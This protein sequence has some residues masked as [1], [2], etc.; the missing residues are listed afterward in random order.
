LRESALPPGA[1][2]MFRQPTLWQQH[3]NLVIGG[4][5]AFGLQTA[6]VAVLLIQM[7][8]RRQAESSLEES[9]ERIAYTAASTNTGL[10]HLDVAGDRG[11]ATDHCRA[12][13]GLAHQAPF[14]LKAILGAVHPED[15]HWVEEAIERATRFGAPIEAEL[16]I[17]V[18][19]REERWFVMRARPH[20]DAHG[21][22]ARI[23]G[24]FADV[25]ARKTAEAE[26]QARRAELAHLTRVSLLGE[27]SGAIAHELNQPLTAILANAQAARLVLAQKKPDLDLIREVIDDIEAEDNRAGEVIHRLRRL[28]RKGESQ[29]EAVNLNDLV[30]STLRVLHSELI[31]RKIKI[32]V[33][34]AGDLPTAAGDPVQL[35][36][37][38]L[39][40][41]MNAME[42]MDATAPA[43]RLITVRTRSDGNGSIEAAVTDRGLGIAPDQQERL[44]QPFFTTKSHGL[45]LGLS[46]CSSIA[47]SHGGA[48]SIGNNVDGGA[49]AVFR[50]PT[51]PA[52]AGAAQAATAGSS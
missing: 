20:F 49:T 36:Q 45:G 29:V 52:T 7:R 22:P 15:R 51:Q 24:I 21:V 31:G 25:T 42:A 47:S 16:R 34:L 17:V 23:A 10:W 8:K 27:L 11:W 41:V 18:P 30:E 44:F 46:I 26:A 13:L 38:L 48:L 50:L 35:Q 9:E 39:N 40:L 33:A 6:V 4:L 32:D 1:V 2:A 43:R 14:R 3:R 12:M 5:A 28:L 19:G 37:V